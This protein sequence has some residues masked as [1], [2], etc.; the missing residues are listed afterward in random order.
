MN[1]LVVSFKWDAHRNWRPLVV[2]F[3]VKWRSA[4]GKNPFF[5]TPTT[6]T[7]TIHHFMAPKTIQRDH[8]YPWLKY[9]HTSTAPPPIQDI[10]FDRPLTSYAR[11]SCRA[12]KKSLSFRPFS[13]SSTG[14]STTMTPQKITAAV[15]GT[16]R[17]VVP[18]KRDIHWN[19]RPLVMVFVVRWTSAHD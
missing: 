1:R 8:S 10:I 6:P 3:V 14:Y 13:I 7:A 16:T 15:H 19:W 17:L 12:T 5:P 2:A 9:Q 4:H 11:P 18:L